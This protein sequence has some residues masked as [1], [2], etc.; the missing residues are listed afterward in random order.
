MQKTRDKT[1][2]FPI[3]GN[4]LGDGETCPKSLSRATPGKVAESSA[5]FRNIAMHK[6]R[7]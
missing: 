2:V 4:D 3:I 5:L 7:F 1:H 6:E